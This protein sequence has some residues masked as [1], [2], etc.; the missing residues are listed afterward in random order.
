MNIHYIKGDATSPTAN[1]D[2]DAVKIGCHICNN[3]GGW[4]SGFV[5]AL[6]NKYGKKAGSPEYEYRKWYKHEGYDYEDSAQ[7]WITVPFQLGRI[8]LVEVGIEQYVC[9]MIA[10][11]EMGGLYEEGERLDCPNVNYSS[12]YECFL[13]LKARL[14]SPAF[15]NKLVELHMPRIGCGLGG[16]TWDKIEAILNKAFAG[17]DIA[18]F[19]YDPV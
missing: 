13:R 12:L 11:N 6:T 19:V 3:Q 1:G 7:G 16:G 14:N 2:R 4:G 8:Q 18:V 10:Q 9:N 15:K 17:T 5:V